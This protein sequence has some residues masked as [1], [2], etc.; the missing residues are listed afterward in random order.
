MRQLSLNQAKRCEFSEHGRCRCR[1]GGELHGAMRG[2][3][4]DFFHTLPETD[5]HKARERREKQPRPRRRDQRQMLLSE[6][7]RGEA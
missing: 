2:L 6:I 1:C 3:D 4:E 7:F 5:P